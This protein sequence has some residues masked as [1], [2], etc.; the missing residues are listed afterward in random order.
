MAG[1]DIGSL[2][3]RIEAR[4]DALMKNV[5][6][7]TRNTARAILNRLAVS[8]PVDEGVA[9][10]NWQVSL[11]GPPVTRLPA[12]FPGNAGSTKGENARAMLQTAR[13]IIPGFYAGKN[14][15]LY[16]GNPIPYIA[17]LNQGSSAQAPAGF[18]ETAIL[19]GS[20]HVRSAAPII[21]GK[22]IDDVSE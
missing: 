4:T 6:V 1:L 14:E 12:Y 21:T 19:A 20:E 2:Q 5:S 10:S 3:V 7:L 16:I 15:T 9:I 17:Q 11:S 13:A 8:T 18:V 22:F